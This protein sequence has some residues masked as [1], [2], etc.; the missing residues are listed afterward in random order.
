MDSKP[1]FTSASEQGSYHLFMA[2]IQPNQTKIAI[3]VANTQEIVILE[4]CNGQ[5]HKNCYFKCKYLGNI[6]ACESLSTAIAQ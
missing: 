2:M 3:F 6:T 4:S 5:S 1:I